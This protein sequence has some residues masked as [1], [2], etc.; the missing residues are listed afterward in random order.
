[1]LCLKQKRWCDIISSKA[2][3]ASTSL[4][5]DHFEFSDP[6]NMDR[7]KRDKWIRFK[8]PQLPEFLTPETEC[9][10]DASKQRK[11]ENIKTV[12]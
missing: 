2:E 12:L 7:M 3:C 5:A 11:H 1:M 6:G 4:V 8:L 10:W 9:G